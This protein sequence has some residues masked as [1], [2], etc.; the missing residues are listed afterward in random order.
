MMES[1]LAVGQ[2]LAWSVQ[3]TPVGSVMGPQLPRG[4]SLSP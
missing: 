3:V 4:L 1:E 2:I